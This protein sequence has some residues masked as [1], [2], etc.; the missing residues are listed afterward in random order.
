MSKRLEYLGRTYELSVAKRVANQLRDIH[1]SF[2]FDVEASGA[3]GRVTVYDNVHF[4]LG[5]Y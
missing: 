2:Y 1:P 4:F 3:F 5:V